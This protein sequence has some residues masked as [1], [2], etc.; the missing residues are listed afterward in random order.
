MR[1]HTWIVIA[2]AWNSEQACE[3]HASASCWDNWSQIGSSSQLQNADENFLLLDVQN[4]AGFGGKQSFSWCIWGFRSG[5]C[6][7]Y[8]L[9]SCNLNYMALDHTL[10]SNFHIRLVQGYSLHV[11]LSWGWREISSR[12]NWKWKELEL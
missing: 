9:Q 11:L 3:L 4:G 10:H 6:E 5:D 2:R 7:K 12:H 8:C 1:S